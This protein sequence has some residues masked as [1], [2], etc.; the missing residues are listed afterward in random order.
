MAAPKKTLKNHK[1]VIILIAYLGSYTVRNHVWSAGR[2]YSK[3]SESC[4][5]AED[6]GVANPQ[7]ISKI[8]HRFDCP[9][10]LLV[11]L[12]VLNL[13]QGLMAEK[14]FLKLQLEP[15]E[16]L[17]KP[18]REKNNSWSFLSDFSSPI[19]TPSECHYVVT[20]TKAGTDLVFLHFQRISKQF[21]VQ[22]GNYWEEKF[23]CLFDFWTTSYALLLTLAKVRALEGGNQFKCHMWLA[24]PNLQLA[25]A[26]SAPH[27]GWDP[28]C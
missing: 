24:K 7:S 27:T 23:R 21:P 12:L 18:S 19:L 3:S 4:S 20:V 16:I 9:L 2:N 28:G 1:A 26:V 25:V 17:R 22:K 11:L 15:E 10:Q 14:C 6:S 5:I 13:W 8:K